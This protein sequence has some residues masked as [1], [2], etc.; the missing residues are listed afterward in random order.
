MVI[1]VGVGFINEFVIDIYI[2]VYER[3]LVFLIFL[4]LSVYLIGGIF[5]IVRNEWIEV[6]VGGW[7]WLNEE[8]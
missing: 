7:F 2:V 4:V 6:R 3:D 5:F 8:E 1:V